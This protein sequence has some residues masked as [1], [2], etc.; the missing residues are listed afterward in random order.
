MTGIKAAFFDIDGTVVS[1][2][3]HRMPD[4]VRSTLIGLH[5]KGVKIVIASGRPIPYI[6][7][8]KDIPV[9]AWVGC[10]GAQIQDAGGNPLF[11]HPIDRDQA[12]LIAR[13]AIENRIPT[14]TFS[15]VESGINCM[16]ERSTLIRDLL[17]IKIPPERDILELCSDY[18]IYEFTTYVT[19]EEEARIYRPILR[20]VEYIRW[21]QMFTDLNPG[22]IDKGVALRRLCEIWGFTPARTAA[23]GDGGNDIP[24]LRAAGI[25][26]A[27]GGAKPEVR[28]AADLQAPSVDD[29][30]IGHTLRQLGII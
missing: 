14:Y 6:D 11:S 12:M 1:F 29:D 15:D 2:K 9:D 8:I 18:P 28:A 24:M 5:D 19:L 26:V 16:N 25:G 10:N 27:M 23:F 4:E 3:T 7:N 22:G 13:T 17:N 21:H 20:N 30:G